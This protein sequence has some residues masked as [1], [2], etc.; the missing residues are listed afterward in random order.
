MSDLMRQ[1]RE[2]TDNP[3][4]RV[5]LFYFLYQ[6]S[7]IN[8]VDLEKIAMKYR[9]KGD[10]LLNDLQL[11]YSFSIPESVTIGE[12]FGV[13]ETQ[14]VPSIYRNLLNCRDLPVLDVPY[15]QLDVYGLDFDPITSLEHECISISYVD[16]QPL[17]N[18]SK[19]KAQFE[20][21][22]HNA[23]NVNSSS[24]VG[25]STPLDFASQIERASQLFASRTSAF[26]A[27]ADIAVKGSCDKD[28]TASPVAM[29]QKF[30]K[31]RIRV[32]VIVRRRSR[33]Y[34]DHLLIL[35]IYI[36]NSIRTI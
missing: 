35:F 25:E 13:L 34:T 10:K 31:N 9:N 32:R 30:M 20:T 26:D 2:R 15:K 1:L 19:F 36:S 29:L 5:L 16:A 33:Y 6:R 3:F 7:K 28:A 12:I 24:S 22:P 11:K 18:I 17:D 14:D 4:A 23:Q 27:I 21:G 8:T